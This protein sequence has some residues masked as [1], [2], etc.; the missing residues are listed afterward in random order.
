MPVLRIEVV[1]EPS[2]RER[3]I[4][5]RL[6]GSAITLVGLLVMVLVLYYH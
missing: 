2:K 1:D 4:N 6:I 5:D 3:K